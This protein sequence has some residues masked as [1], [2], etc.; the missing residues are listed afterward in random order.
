MEKFNLT[1]LTNNECLLINGG[2]EPA[3]HIGYYLRKFL[4]ETAEWISENIANGPM[5]S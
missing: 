5:H 2:A 3:Y 4:C 1:E